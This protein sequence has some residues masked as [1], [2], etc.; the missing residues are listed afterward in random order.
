MT[1]PLSLPSGCLDIPAR[2][3]LT[4][5]IVSRHVLLGQGERSALE[6]DGDEV[7]FAELDAWTDSVG[8]ALNA[9][10]IGGGDRFVI[11]APNSVWYVLAVLGGM[12]AGAVPVLVSSTC[13]PAAVK[14]IVQRTHA[15]GVL[16]TPEFPSP[17]GRRLGFPTL[18][19]ALYDQPHRAHQALPADTGADDTAYVTCVPDGGGELR[20]VAYAHRV[21]IAA[22]DPIRYGLLRLTPDD[23]C[24]MPAPLSAGFALDFSLYLPLS[25]GARALI[26]QGSADPKSVLATIDS[27]Q[28]SVL[29]GT[30]ALYREMCSLVAD[31][32]FDLGSLRLALSLGGELP[33]P[34][35]DELR[36]RF[37][38]DVVALAAQPETHVFAASP[39]DD[40]RRE[41]FGLPLPGRV[42]EVVTEGGNQAAV[43]QVGQLCFP[44][45]DPA[46]ASGYDGMDAEWW[47]KH[48]H[49]W[50][51]SG[52]LAYRD[53]DGCL[54]RATP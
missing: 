36:R 45:G 4:D 8:T 52:H 41:A 13:R 54:R 31:G 34:L 51:H 37:G 18:D 25:A 9:A 50:Y 21:V 6:C 53:E 15:K 1:F 42:V 5:H 7:T 33:G 28:V 12:K 20:A 44:S 48:E 38:L 30:P 43:G 46:L 32:L 14:A 39:E 47:A 19:L 11:W 24:L 29:V 22:G 3:N 16:V 40:R 35:L 49:G 2:L 27:K 17:K 23:T 26:Y 10:G